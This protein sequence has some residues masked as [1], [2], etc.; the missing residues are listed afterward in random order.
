MKKCGVLI[1]LAGVLLW[2]STLSTHFLRF[3]TMEEYARASDL[4]VMATPIEVKTKDTHSLEVTFNVSTVFRGEYPDRTL[5]ICHE[6]PTAG[7]KWPWLTTS[8]P[9]DK[10]FLYLNHGPA[11]KYIPASGLANPELAIR[12]L[13]H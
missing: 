7:E 1:L 10:Y 5:V 13:K 8:N 6:A 4:F 2:M 11:G 3:Q 12:K 9:R